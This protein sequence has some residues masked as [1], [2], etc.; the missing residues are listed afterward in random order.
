[1]PTDRNKVEQWSLSYHILKSYVD[2]CFKF[3]FKTSVEGLGNIPKD[4]PLIFAPNHQNALMDA[5]AV[6]STK[7]W[8]PVFLARADIFNNPAISKILT[9]FKIMPVYRIRDGYS[10]LQKNDEI[11]NKTIDVIKNLNGL[12]ILPEGNHGDLK[13]LRPLKKGI[14][15]IALQAEEACT[16]ELDIH[17]VP[18]GL[19]YSNYINVGSKLH[20]RFGAP[21]GVRPF[22]KHYQ[23]NAAKGYNMLIE[24][25]EKGMRVE[26][27]D[28]KDEKY[29]T[30]YDIVLK[31]FTPEYIEI[32]K[33]PNNHSNIVDSQK[34]IINQIDRFKRSRYDDF[35][36]LAA[37]ALE[38]NLLLKRR[39]LNASTYLVKSNNWWSILP[40]SFALLILLPIFIFSFLNNI[41]PLSIIKL[42]TKKIADKQFISSVRFGLGVVLFPLFQL[43]QLIALTLLTTG[44]IY[45]IVYAI[46]L[47]LSVFFFFTYKGWAMLTWEKL[48]EERINLLESKKDK[49]LKNLNEGIKKQMWNIMVFKE[50]EEYLNC[51]VVD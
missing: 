14:V 37:D 45:P 38:Y 46:S 23:E 12:V 47:P 3:Y 48:K 42:F 8:Q 29:Y 7:T 9:F 33:F 36:L 49:R 2:F 28:I 19:D 32:K 43:V 39:S 25:I 5:L 17:I 26:M 22:L 13:R 24:Q 1:M 41:I 31:T 21:I 18:V 15:R 51:P 11:F 35:L 50:E 30:V 44:W 4:K 40:V 16:E 34:L 27:I 6:L 10:N 20:I